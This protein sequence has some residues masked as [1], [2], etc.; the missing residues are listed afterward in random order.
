MTCSHS[1]LNG[2]LHSRGS[3][4]LH[5]LVHRIEII[6]S[7]VGQGITPMESAEQL[8][9][10]EAESVSNRIEDRPAAVSSKT[11]H[12][13]P[14]TISTDMPRTRTFFWLVCQS[15]HHHSGA[16]K[17]HNQADPGK[18]NR[19]LAHLLQLLS[20]ETLSCLSCTPP[21]YHTNVKK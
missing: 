1:A 5:G 10:S 6:A 21:L 8:F 9:R 16:Q 13:D 14:S 4:S 19:P 12:T 15:R 18:N 2:I 3:G 11:H 17:K 20:P 7:D